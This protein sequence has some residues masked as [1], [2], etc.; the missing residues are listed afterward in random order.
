MALT[1]AIGSFVAGI[2]FERLPEE[3]VEV[4]RTGF[5]DTIA[6]MIA[7]AGDEAPQLLRRAHSRARPPLR[8]RRLTSPERWPS[9]GQRFRVTSIANMS[10]TPSSRFFSE[11]SL[12]ASVR[13]S[14]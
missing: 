2:S 10:R 4:A 6:T 8:R 1:Q 11:A 14:R 13:S 3:A 7:G 9:S 5:I 12:Q